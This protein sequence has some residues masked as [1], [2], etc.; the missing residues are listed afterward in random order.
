MKKVSELNKAELLEHMNASGEVHRYSADSKAWQRAFALA[1][2]AGV[3]AY[4][5]YGCTKCIQK[6][7]EWLKTE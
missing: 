1:M 3:I 7:D 5:D 4:I 6:V 2:E